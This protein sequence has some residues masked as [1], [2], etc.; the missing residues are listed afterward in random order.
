MMRS[1]LHISIYSVGSDNLYKMQQ[2]HS[3]KFLCIPIC[4]AWCCTKHLQVDEAEKTNLFLFLE[5][6]NDRGVEKLKPAMQ[7]CTNQTILKCE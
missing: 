6:N 2:I 5:R 4:H 3:V 1:E 7:I